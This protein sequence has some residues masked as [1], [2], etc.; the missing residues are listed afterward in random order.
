M[1]KQTI[2][3][4]V[5]LPNSSRIKVRIPY[6][7]KTERERF[8][9]FHSAF[10]HP[11]QKLWSIINTAENWERLQKEF[12]HKIEIKKLAKF[13]PLPQKTINEKIQAELAKAEQKLILKAFSPNTIKAYMN[14]IK[15]FF[16][17]FR[18]PKFF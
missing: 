16:S 1:N 17:F 18:N 6:P 15:T 7:M 2:T 13:R 3:L 8:K 11:N 14:E 10:Y 5:P 12:E 4:Y 9:T